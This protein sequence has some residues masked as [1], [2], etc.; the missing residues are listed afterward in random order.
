MAL[1][2]SAEINLAELEQFFRE[3]KGERFFDSEFA[4][5]STEDQK[6]LGEL[7]LSLK[8]S[9]SQCRNFLKSLSEVSKR[10]E[11][12]FGEIW[13]GSEIAQLVSDETLKPLVR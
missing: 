10:D 8:P 3:K 7:F 12:S 9:I 1:E 6:V 2:M 11:I 4:A 13:E 5:L